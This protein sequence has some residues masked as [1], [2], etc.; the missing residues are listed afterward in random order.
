[1]SRD[2]IR[3]GE[4]RTVAE[5]VKRVLLVTLSA[6][7]SQNN[8]ASW[9]ALDEQCFHLEHTCGP[10]VCYAVGALRTKLGICADLRSLGSQ[11][12]TFRH[13]RSSNA[14][15]HKTLFSHGFSVLFPVYH[16]GIFCQGL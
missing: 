13:F 7:A 11:H 15:L 14:Q 12:W 2:Q 16:T 10:T 4:E 9:L 1:M 5:R 3:V 6:I 8:H